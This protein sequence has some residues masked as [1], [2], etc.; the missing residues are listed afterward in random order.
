[1]CD[2]SPNARKRARLLVHN[3]SLGRNHGGS[4][5]LVEIVERRGDAGCIIRLLG[6]GQVLLEQRLRPGVV[7]LVDGDDAK[8]VQRPGDT[9]LVPN[10]PRDLRLS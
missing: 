2:S 10:L 8:I 9:A 1:M 5:R 4:A 6:D 7:T 3:S